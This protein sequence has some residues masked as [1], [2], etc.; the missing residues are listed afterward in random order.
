LNAHV[1]VYTQGN[2]RSS[3]AAPS[4]PDTHTLTSTLLVLA[5]TM[6]GTSEAARAAADGLIEAAEATHNP[7][8]LAN[9]L[10]TYSWPSAI[11]IPSARWKPCAG[12][13]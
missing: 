11:L 10:Y 13:W 7:W 4:S 1:R 9:A 2:V 3:G 5:T 6:A 12:A 8:A